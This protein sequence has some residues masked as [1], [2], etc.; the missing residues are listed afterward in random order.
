M[1]NL[2]AEFKTLEFLNQQLDYIM[3]SP[4]NFGE[5]KLIV[6]RPNVGERREIKTGTLSFIEGLVGDGWKNRSNF[7]AKNE[8]PDV[9]MQLTL[10]NS[11]VIE[12]IAGAQENWKWAGDQIFVD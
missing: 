6:V 2:M 9:D 3:A 5:V 8:P 11:R 7:L 4:K 12:S 1:K 10:M